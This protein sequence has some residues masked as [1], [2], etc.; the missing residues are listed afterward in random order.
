MRI[1]YVCSKEFTWGSILFQIGVMRAWFVED[2]IKF[3]NEVFDGDEMKF[4][5]HFEEL[6]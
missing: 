5:E 1:L 3:T 4:R 6:K 2:R